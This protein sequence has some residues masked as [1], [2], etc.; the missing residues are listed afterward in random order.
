MATIHSRVADGSLLLLK[1]RS[2]AKCTA[3]ISQPAGDVGS[4]SHLP[5]C[6]RH[7]LSD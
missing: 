1:G 5:L 7:S 2:G 6:E 3:N 4:D